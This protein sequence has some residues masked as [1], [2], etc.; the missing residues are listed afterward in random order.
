[1]SFFFDCFIARFYIE[2]YENNNS[3]FLRILDCLRI[4]NNSDIGKELFS[5]V[6]NFHLGVGAILVGL[7]FFVVQWEANWNIALSKGVIIKESNIIGLIS[8][9]ILLLITL[10]IIRFESNIYFLFNSNII[11]VPYIIYCL[12]LLYFL[13]KIIVYK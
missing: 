8:T 12:E 6:F 3:V 7:I 10:V 9:Y 11:L 4:N 2:S 5:L 1:M 13:I